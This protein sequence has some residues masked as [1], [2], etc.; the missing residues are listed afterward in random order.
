[1]S[2]KLE[3]TVAAANPLWR[4]LFFSY[5]QALDPGTPESARRQLI[6]R[7]E[8][9]IMIN[10][11]TAHDW[12]GREELMTVSTYLAP[13]ALR[14]AIDYIEHHATSALTLSDI[15]QAASC[16]I[17]SLQ[18]AFANALNQTPM[19]YVKQV[20]LRFAR[21]ALASASVAGTVTS[22]ASQY[23]FNHLGQFAVDYR[24]AFGER[25]SETLRR[26]M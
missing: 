5:T 4:A 1:M 17:R 19:Q 16:S 22:I 15:A 24:K 10:L 13:A 3:A 9:M 2:F 21:D 7:V 20:R 26:R 23:G 8:E 11:L 14:R 18:R 25:P 12:V 6:R